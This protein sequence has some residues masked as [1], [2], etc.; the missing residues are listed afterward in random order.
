MESLYGEP[1]PVS[2]IVASA[3]RHLKPPSGMSATRQPRAE[4]S[5]GLVWQRRRSRGRGPAYRVH[6]R[7]MVRVDHPGPAVGTHNAANE[8][9][10]SSHRLYAPAMAI[11]EPMLGTPAVTWPADGDWMMEPKWDGF[12]LLV[13]VGDDARIRAW[14]RRGTSLGDRLGSLLEPLAA[15]IT[16]PPHATGSP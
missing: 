15:A 1:M 9:W 3:G 6:A 13:E 11:P 14:S 5:V 16:L 2:V 10:P 4:C 8:R 7:E 12:R